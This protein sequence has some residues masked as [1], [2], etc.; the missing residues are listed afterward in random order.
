MNA[1][2]EIIFVLALEFHFLEYFVFF[3]TLTGEICK[4][5]MKFYIDFEGNFVRK[6]EEYVYEPETTTL[7]Y[8]S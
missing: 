3:F 2:N 6:R 8:M 4:G 5:F 1:R 7:R